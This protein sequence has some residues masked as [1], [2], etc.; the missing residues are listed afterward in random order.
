[1]CQYGPSISATDF[2]L[3]YLIPVAAL[4]AGWLLLNLAVLALVRSSMRSDL[5]EDVLERYRRKTQLR[6]GTDLKLSFGF[7]ARLMMDNT[8][9]ATMLY[10]V[11]RLLVRHRLAS[12][13]RL[14]HAF[15]RVV[16]SSDLNPGAVIGPGFYLYHGLGTVIG[17]GSHLGAR[18]LVCQGVTTGGGHVRVGDDVS[19]WAGAKVI[20]DVTVGD[21]SEIG[22]NAVVVADVPADTVAVGVPAT[23]HVARPRVESL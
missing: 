1:M 22:A 15:A 23:R 17:K 20:G 9:W 21:R 3:V 8:V 4:V 18:V 19:I 12:L 7:V 10:R 5:K 14:V 16:T 6:S 11:S 2:L 13:G